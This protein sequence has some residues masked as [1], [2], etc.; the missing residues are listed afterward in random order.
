MMEWWNNITLFEKVFWFIASPFS[1][2]FLIQLVLTFIGLGG[3]SEVD[4]DAD[5]DIDTDADIDIDTDVDIDIDTDVD[6]DID[7][8]ADIDIDADADI[9]ID[10]DADID[11]D[12]DT[13]TDTDKD[14]STDISGF[15][16][17][18]IRSIIAFFTVF[19]WAGI[20]AINSGAN[21]VLSIIVALV[22][23]IG[24]M[25]LVAWIFYF[26]THLTESGN[27]SIRNALN[28]TGTV[29]IPI[30]EN[31]SGVGKVQ[32]IIQGSTREMDAITNGKII[33]TGTKV[34]VIGIIK[35]KL[36]LVER[37]K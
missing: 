35:N 16:L 14:A 26:I 19:G 18:T 29:Y 13:D 5:V 20:V 28:T 6:I 27:I 3:E 36:L 4:T 31:K 17:L 33:P 32:L 11:T 9:D 23:G 2:I 25:A 7:A 15:R 30:P 24:M 1:V 21:E 8:D 12:T 22:L 10:T 34:R 37:L